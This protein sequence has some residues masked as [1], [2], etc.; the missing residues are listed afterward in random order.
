M[1]LYCSCQLTL[2][3]HSARMAVGSLGFILLQSYAPL[4]YYCPHVFLSSFFFFKDP[5]LSQPP[6]FPVCRPTIRL[7]ACLRFVGLPSPL[8]SFLYFVY[9]ASIC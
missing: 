2:F 3:T 8:L 4:S 6:A 7:G 5:A 1:V 9:F